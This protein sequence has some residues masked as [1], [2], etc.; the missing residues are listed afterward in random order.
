MDANYKGLSVEETVRE[1][2]RRY[3]PGKSI[4]EVMA[5]YF[6]NAGLFAIAYLEGKPHEVLLERLRKIRATSENMR[7]RH[8]DPE[9]ARA[10]SE[11]M[12]LRHQEPEFARAQSERTRMLHQDPE[13]ARAE[14]E[15]M[16]ML[17]QDPEFARARD[18]RLRRL[19]EDP[20]FA[21]ANSERLR[22][23]HRDRRLA[24]AREERLRRMATATATPANQGGQA[25]DPNE[26]GRNADPDRAPK[27]E[28]KASARVIAIR[29]V[30]RPDE[31]YDLRVGLY[32]PMAATVAIDRQIE[33]TVQTR[34]SVYNNVTTELDEMLKE[35]RNGE[36]PLNPRALTL[37]KMAER[38]AR[39]QQRHYSSQSLYEGTAET[40]KRREEESARK[41]KI[42]E[43]IAESGIRLRK[44]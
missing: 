30:K 34:E 5:T 39:T 37:A 24:R 8:Q 22:K 26:V 17:H 11:R 10:N 43:R 18:E 29:R 23:R 16:R 36:Y 32:V 25:A 44:A 33:T 35:F 21:R 6:P 15:R 14:S 12:R 27:R 31:D 9:F 4:D 28:P 7:L 1:L 38:I 40:W 42:V 13:F 19:N 41:R 20:E 3:Y 2:R